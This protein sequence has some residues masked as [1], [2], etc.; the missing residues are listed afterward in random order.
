MSW[1]NGGV[2]FE[3]IYLANLLLLYQFST[4]N[5]ELLKGKP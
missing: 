5:I 2:E 4:I 3:F 1:I